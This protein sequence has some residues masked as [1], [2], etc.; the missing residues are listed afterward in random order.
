MELSLSFLRE[1]PDK[2]RFAELSQNFCDQLQL[3]E[4]FFIVKLAQGILKRKYAK[5]N[6]K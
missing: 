1:N 6:F 3:V 4:Q 2:L 5:T